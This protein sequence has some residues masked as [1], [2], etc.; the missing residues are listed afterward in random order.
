MTAINE[1]SNEI[2][3]GNPDF[4]PIKPSDYHK[5]VVLSLGTGASKCGD[6][7]CAENAAKWGMLGWVSNAG[8]CPLMEVFMQASGDMVDFHL[9]TVFKALHCENNYIR[10]Q[11]YTSIIYITPCVDLFFLSIPFFISQ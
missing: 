7:Y 8:S 11:V 10:I 1:V 2:Y 9:H 6:K 4:Y 5:Y 3:S